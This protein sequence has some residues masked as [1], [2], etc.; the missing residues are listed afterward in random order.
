MTQI[1]RPYD[2]EIIVNDATVFTQPNLTTRTPGIVFVG[3]ERIYFWHTDITTPGA[4]K[5]Y[6]LLRGTSGTPWGVT[7]YPDTGQTVTFNSGNSS[8]TLNDHG[9]RPGQDV[10][11]QVSGGTL[12]TG[13]TASTTYYVVEVDR[14]NFQIATSYTNASANPPAIVSL[15]AG[16]G[17]ILLF[18]DGVEVIDGGQGQNIPLSQIKWFYTPDG[19]ILTDNTFADF[20]KASPGSDTYTG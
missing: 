1:L 2:T 4:N 10:T 20:L 7:Y 19:L 3:A 9:L 5:L 17:T 11:F 8:F 16:S 6:Q 12:P 18:V 14:N 15:T 13:M